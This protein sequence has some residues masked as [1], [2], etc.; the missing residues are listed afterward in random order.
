MASEKVPATIPKED[1]RAKHEDSGGS[2]EEAVIDETANV[3]GKVGFLYQL[4]CTR[5]LTSFLADRGKKK[6]KKKKP[7]KKKVEQ[8][9]PPRVGLSKIFNDVYPE[10]EIQPYRDES[11]LPEHALRVKLIIRCS[12]AWRTTS[13]EKRYLEKMAMEDPD[14]TYQHIRRAAEV[15]RQVRHHARKYIRP[16][17]SMTEI[18]EY[19]ENGTRALVEENGLECGIGF[20][21]GLSLNH[22]AAHFTPNAGDTTSTSTCVC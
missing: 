5:W 10:G 22:C 9:D 7:K 16:G 8:S 11:V 4:C 18:A 21:T 14:V 13:E 20:P 19:I 12:N 17:M 6:K 1:E 2:G 15:H 3:V